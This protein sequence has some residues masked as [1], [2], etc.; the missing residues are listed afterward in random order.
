M[1]YVYY[2][3]ALPCEAGPLIKHFK[4]KKELGYSA[5]SIYRNKH[6]TLTVTG[7][8]K[9]AMA[10]GVAYT[11]ALVP[12]PRLPVLLNIGI[13][14][15]RS[16]KLGSV[17][18]AQ[19]IT[20]L[21]AGR[22]FYPQ[23]VTSPPCPTQALNTV[24]QAQNDYPTD[25]LYDMEASAFYETA[26]RFSSSELIHCIKVISDNIENPTHEIK[27]VQVSQLLTG[28][29][30]VIEQYQQQLEKLASLSEPLATTNHYE[31]IISQWHF[32]SSEKLQLNSLLNKRAVL[33]NQP[34]VLDLNTL[35]KANNKEVLD[36]LREE[37]DNVAFGG[38]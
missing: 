21:D 5:F 3:A 8:G 25:S 13:A 7:L 2:F 4:L 6:L 29:L 27:P 19:K 22:K 28:T 20:D 36:F 37:I 12:T 23:L 18:I 17:L 32:T 31:Q 1:T 16:Y 15:H 10:A 26:M 33:T 38:F 11:L 24:A 9:S 30:P 35:K 34:D 14:G